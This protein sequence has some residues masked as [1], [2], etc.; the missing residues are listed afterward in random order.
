MHEVQPHLVGQR[1]LSCGW[2]NSSRVKVAHK[3]LHDAFEGQRCFFVVVRTNCRPNASLPQYRNADLFVGGGLDCA[4][5]IS[6]H[7]SATSDVLDLRITSDRR[8]YRSRIAD[9]TNSM[10]HPI[11][12]CR[13]R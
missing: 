11:A 1:R 9:P 4:I 2:L 12:V 6:D 3:D 10:V 7:P 13:E 8:S 5:A